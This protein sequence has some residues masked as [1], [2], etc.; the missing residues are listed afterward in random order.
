M[1]QTNLV[2]SPDGK[3]W[4]E[5]RD[6]SYIGPMKVSVSTDTETQNGTANIVM[7]NEIRG[8]LNQFRNYFTKDFTMAYD[9]IICLV[10]GQ[11]EFNLWCY[12]SAATHTWMYIN[13]QQVG[14]SYGDTSSSSNNSFTMTNHLFRGD[15]VQ[16]KGGFG[17]DGRIYNGFQITRLL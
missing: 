5:L 3:T 16:V 13:G 8:D 10:D 11:Y 15:Y 17:T 9:R 14:T 6:T 1:E 4:D 12:N 7:F 2:I